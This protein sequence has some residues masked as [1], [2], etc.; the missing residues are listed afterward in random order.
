MAD[1]EGAAIKLAEG[2]LASLI[3][4]SNRE[5]YLDLNW[6]IGGCSLRDI[7]SNQW[8]MVELA[9]MRGI[10]TTKETP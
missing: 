6:L 1:T 9:K 10:D 8:A 2:E 3:R 7:P 5:N 4:M